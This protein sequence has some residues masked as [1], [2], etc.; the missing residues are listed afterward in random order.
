MPPRDSFARFRRPS[1]RSHQGQPIAGAARSVLRSRRGAALTLVTLGAVL[2]HAYGAAA[3]FTIVQ[4]N[5]QFS[6]PKITIKLGD[7]IT[8]VNGDGVNHHVFSDTKGAEIDLLQRPGRSDTVRFTQPGTVE[9]E[10]A[11]HPD[12]RLEV[13]VRP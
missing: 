4:K 9:I 12:M 7:R 2:V 11:V 8:F 3:D 13:Q 10:C 5:K 6:V 1:L